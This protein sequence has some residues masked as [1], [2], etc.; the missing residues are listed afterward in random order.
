MFS[1]RSWRLHVGAIDGCFSAETAEIQASTEFLQW[2]QLNQS[3]AE[4]ER[5]AMSLPMEDSAGL[6]FNINNPEILERCLELLNELREGIETGFNKDRDL[7]ILGR[8]YGSDEQ[9]HLHNT[10]YQKYSMWLCTAEAS[11]EERKIQN[12]STPE[13]CAHNVRCEID[14]ETK[15]LTVLK[16]ERKSVEAAR[17]SLETVRLKV[18]ES[19]TLDRLLRYE[20]ALERMF[21]RTLSQLERLQ[22]MRLGEPV[23]PRID[24]NLSS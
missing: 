21:E 1:L 12:Y 9:H 6:I 10:L 19:P 24:L 17:L 23:A 2:D 16:E 18:P 20:A 3:R 13:Q 8:L 11:E 7:P 14:A 15:R 5:L 4:A 22:R